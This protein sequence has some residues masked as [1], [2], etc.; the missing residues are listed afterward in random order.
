MGIAAFVVSNIVQVARQ[1]FFA[2]ESLHSKV[3][4]ECGRA[5]K[6]EMVAIERARTTA[7]LSIEQE[8]VRA[9]F[10][11]ERAL[12]RQASP[13]DLDK[14]CATD[15]AGP[16]ARAALARFERAAESHALREA[17]DLRPVRLDAESFISGP[18]R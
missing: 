2:Q 12:A 4:E 10:T 7:S 6:E 5:I 9:K 14:A 16:Q 8:A 11:A 18:P 3:S 17:T 13:N 15:P 1:L